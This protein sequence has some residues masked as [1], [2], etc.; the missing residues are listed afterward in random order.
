[1]A[2][3]LYKGK[4]WGRAASPRTFGRIER[5]DTTSFCEMRSCTS[6]A[7][8]KIGYGELGVVFC[9]RHTVM[10]MRS[11]RVWHGR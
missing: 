2:G 5:I 3:Y 9:P 11:N 4:N 10:I 6:L 1:M 8:W 7:A